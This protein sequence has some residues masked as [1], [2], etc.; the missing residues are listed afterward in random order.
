[1]KKGRD[2]STL[3]GLILFTYDIITLM[4]SSLF[5]LLIMGEE[6]LFASFQ[7]YLP[8][9]II[10]IGSSVIIYFIFKLYN[11]L[12][13]YASVGEAIR[14]VVATISVLII[15]VIMRLSVGLPSMRWAVS[16]MFMQ[17]LFA[18]F[19]RF[20]YRMY[21]NLRQGNLIGFSSQAK[22]RRVM[23]VGAGDAGVSIASEMQT[24]EVLNMMPVCFIDDDYRKI[25][26]YINGIKVVGNRDDL[27][28]QAAKH[29]IDLI[30][31]AIPSSDKRD[32][33]HI[34]NICKD[35]KCE[36]KFLPGTKSLLDDK[37]LL[38]NVKSVEITDL[39]GREQIE[40]NMDEIMGYIENK[41]IMVTGGGGSIGSELCRQIALHSPKQLI[42]FDIYENNAY[43][44][45]QELKRNLPLL[46]LLVLKVISLVN[47]KIIFLS[48][49]FQTRLKKLL[50]PL[51]NFFINFLLFIIF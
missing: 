11:S 17:F 7:E 8:Y 36:I 47:G 42:I 45:E 43:E 28:A 20:A 32:V 14:I 38:Q 51:N 22:K 2:N 29:H 40:V 21:K 3:K 33:K 30:I 9:S 44:I 49:N 13:K 4:L 31:V 48:I 23:I 19:V 35:T 24:S 15:N 1:M 10:A 46:N 6:D 34:L 39:L 37:N 41:V 25:N 26:S 16:F 18:C 27:P 50:I 5:A 12:W